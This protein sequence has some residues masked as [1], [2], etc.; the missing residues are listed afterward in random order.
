LGRGAVVVEPLFAGF[1]RFAAFA[2]PEAQ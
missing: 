2:D 1:N